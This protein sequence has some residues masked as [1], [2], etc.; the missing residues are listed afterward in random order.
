MTTRRPVSLKTFS[1]SE[2]SLHLTRRCITPDIKD[3]K[4]KNDCKIL[5]SSILWDHTHYVLLG[6]TPQYK[7][8]YSSD[9]ELV[10]VI[11]MTK[12]HGDIE[13]P[14]SVI[15]R[16]IKALVSLTQ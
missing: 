9:D 15:M 1:I 13:I 10:T 12:D 16:R 6:T 7:I 2:F 14:V 4:E 5:F 8:I 11:K 3:D